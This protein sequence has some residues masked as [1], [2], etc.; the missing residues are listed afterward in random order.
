M[1]RRLKGIRM[2]RGQRIRRELSKLPEL[3]TRR[4]LRRAVRA[5]LGHSTT[6]RV[7]GGIVFTAVLVCA[8]AVVLW[9][10]SPREII[11]GGTI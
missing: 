7:A 4:E 5:A 11:P 9:A 6:G 3:P 1:S 2:K 8:V 10:L